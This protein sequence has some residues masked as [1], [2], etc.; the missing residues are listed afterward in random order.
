MH[1]VPIEA[2]I[3]RSVISDRGELLW[4]RARNVR[5]EIGNLVATD[6][7]DVDVRRSFFRPDLEVAVYAVG[8][9]EGTKLVSSKREGVRLVICVGREDYKDQ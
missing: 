6:K 7:K 9:V 8:V 2:S 3:W 4:T 5:L 1:V